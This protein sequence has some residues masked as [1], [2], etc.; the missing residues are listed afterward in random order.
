MLI[1]KTLPLDAALLTI[2]VALVDAS[3]TVA[4]LPIIVVTFTIFG[5]AIF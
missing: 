5:A 2:A 1:L 4:D 3:A